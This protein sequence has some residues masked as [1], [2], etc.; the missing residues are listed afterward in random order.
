M[1]LDA[2]QPARDAMRGAA[3]AAL[4]GGTGLALYLAAYKLG[5]SLNVVPEDLPAVWWRIP[6]LILNAAQN[7]I[8]EEVLIIGYLLR[9]LDQLGWTPWRAIVFSAVLRGSYHLYQGFG[10][11]LGNATMG[12]ISA[13][14]GSWR[15]WRGGMID[16]Y[17]RL[18]LTLFPGSSGGAV[19]NTQGKVLGT[20][21]RF[22]HMACGEVFRSLGTRTALA[23]SPTG[24]RYRASDR[25]PI[26]G[27]PMLSSPVLVLAWPHSR[28]PF[29]AGPVTWRGR[30][31]PGRQAGGR[32]VRRAATAWTAARR[33]RRRP[34]AQPRPQRPRRPASA[35]AARSG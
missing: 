18:D 8:L 6:I 24:L 27:S 35:P 13:V 3:L 32:A 4:I 23:V 7:G 25:A 2:S 26:P 11:F 16:Q 14:S 9:R 10:G 21:P 15:T 20:I 22:H 1:G 28:C 29:P 17:I 5:I 33:C 30:R 19:I 12:V 31:G 34:A